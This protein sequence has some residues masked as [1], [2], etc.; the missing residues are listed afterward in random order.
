MKLT[1]SKLK[2]IIREEIQKLNEDRGWKIINTGQRTL[3]KSVFNQAK[4]LFP[5]I[6]PMKKHVPQAGYV[7][8]FKDDSGN[9]IGMVSLDKPHG[10]VIRVK[11]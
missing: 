2:E 7:Y 1:K 3:N 8:Y 9:N 11:Q 4:K 6:K 5:G 10:A